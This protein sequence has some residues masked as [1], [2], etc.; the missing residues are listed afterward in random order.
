MLTLIALPPAQAQS[1][2]VIYNFT[3]GQD[4][5]YLEAGL[6]ERGGSLY[7]TAYAGGSANSGTV[8]KL[9]RNGSGWTFAVAGELLFLPRF[10]RIPRP[11]SI[12]RCAI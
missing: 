8:F 3:G 7:G 4:G 11:A 2:H 10:L 12:L 1:Y 9:A 5:A 6:T